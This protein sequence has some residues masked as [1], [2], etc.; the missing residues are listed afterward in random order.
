MHIPW[1]VSYRN[2]RPTRAIQSLI[3]EKVAGLEKFYPRIVRCH[4]TVERPGRHHR[5]GPGAHFRVRIELSVPGGRLVVGR[6]PEE[7]KEHEDAYLAISE[8]FRAM[9]RQLQDHA[10]RQRGDVKLHALPELA[11]AAPA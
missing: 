6:D 8:A 3:D 9:R 1:E 2:V 7:A 11:P 5:R 4:V 10:R